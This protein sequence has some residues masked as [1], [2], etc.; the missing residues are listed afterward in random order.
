MEN[1]NNYLSLITSILTILGIGGIGTWAIFKRGIDALTAKQI[2]V[3]FSSFLF[4][5]Y[6]TFFP[7]H[8]NI[9]YNLFY[10]SEGKEEKIIN[11]L[12]V[13]RLYQVIQSQYNY[14]HEELNTYEEDALI[15]SIK[16][17]PFILFLFYPFLFFIEAYAIKK[18]FKFW[19]KLLLLLQ[20][21]L[22]FW[23]LR[24]I[25]GGILFV[26]ALFGFMEN[27]DFG[28][29]TEDIYCMPFYLSQLSAFV[30]ALWSLLLLIPYIRA[31]TILSTPFNKL[32]SKQ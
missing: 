3:L 31:N 28:R 25:I 27:L 7:S 2:C 24:A 23:G 16:I 4:C 10:N 8:K 29:G 5:T 15:N 12:N 26:N 19:H 14:G 9:E 11:K 18:P 22:L 1:T 17:I 21:A 13:T 20:T 32:S 6:V 30:F